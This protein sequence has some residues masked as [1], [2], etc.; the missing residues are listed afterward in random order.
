ME[1]A[2]QSSADNRQT[3]LKDITLVPCCLSELALEDIDLSTI[4]GESRLENPIIINAMTGG[5]QEAEVINQRLAQLAAQC[6]LG[7]AVGSQRAGLEDPELISSYSIVR[8]TNPEGLIWANLDAGSSIN[9]VQQAISMIDA[10]G[11]QMHLNQ[12]QELAMPEGE[13]DFR[14]IGK[15]LEVVA[16]QVTV[17]VIAKVVGSGIAAEEA[18]YLRHI[19]IDIVDIGGYGGTNF[20]NI[21]NRRGGLL[22]QNFEYWGLPTAVAL[23]ECL[24][25]DG[26]RVIASGGI[27]TALDAAKCLAMGSA[28]ASMALPFLQLLDYSME[29]RLAA[30][31][32]F[33]YQLKCVLL[34]CGARNIN[35]LRQRPLVIS[36]YTREWME[37]RGLV[38]SR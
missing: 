24:T 34:L 22:G 17:P 31:N 2:R 28:A 29:D 38:L 37:S 26:L 19:G 23:A 35:E 10:D 32:Q 13:R 12:A 25:V 30:V 36:G 20:I 33:I 14:C 18:K 6:G 7:M 16:R 8:A 4:I 27:R 9:E 5:C 1:L 3:L 15:S 21:E 11:I